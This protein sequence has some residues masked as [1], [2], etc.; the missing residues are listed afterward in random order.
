M[1]SAN[2][3]HRNG[4]CTAQSSIYESRSPIQRQTPPLHA[5]KYCAADE[6][7]IVAQIGFIEPMPGA[8]HSISHAR[9]SRSSLATSAMD[10][11]FV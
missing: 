9:A 7:P 8:E 6:P 1:G 11:A 5:V 3:V 4:K 2:K 10:A